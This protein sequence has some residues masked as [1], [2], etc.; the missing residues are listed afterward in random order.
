[1]VTDMIKLS[2]PSILKSHNGFRLVY[3]DLTLAHSK[4]QSEIYDLNIRV[5]LLPWKMRCAKCFDR[6]SGYFVYFV[7]WRLIAVLELHTT[8]GIASLNR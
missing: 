8:I 6:P 3:F 4:V 5:G 2:L 1:M 7:Q